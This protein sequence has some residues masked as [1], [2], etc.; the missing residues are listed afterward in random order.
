MSWWVRIEYP[1]RSFVVQTGQSETGDRK[2]NA[3]T[4]R[5]TP[6]IP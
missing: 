3:A 1:A 6:G 2:M 5:S 4:R